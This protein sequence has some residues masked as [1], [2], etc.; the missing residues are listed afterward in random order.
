MDFLRSYLLTILIF[1]PSVGAV[2]VLFLRSR[3]AVRK[4]ALGFTLV[5]FALSLL[6]FAYFDWSKGD[7]YGYVSGNSKGVVQMEHTA[8]W[9]PA[10]NIQYKVGIDGLSF[11]LVI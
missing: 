2:S 8:A 10:F 3:D 5:T 11:P 6:L 9:I 1:L 4:T 7:A